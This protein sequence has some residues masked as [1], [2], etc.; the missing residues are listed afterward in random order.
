MGEDSIARAAGCL[1][2]I[3]IAAASGVLA[4]RA[5]E[6]KRHLAR[7]LDIDPAL[8]ISTLKSVMGPFR[9]EYLAKYEN[10]LRKAGLPE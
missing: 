9:P 10:A 4:G 2:R 8:R 5:E 7:L 1:H 6:A 3:A